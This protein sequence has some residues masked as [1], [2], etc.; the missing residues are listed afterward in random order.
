MERR[1]TSNVSISNDNIKCLIEVSIFAVN[2]TLKLFRATVAN[3]DI[4]GQKSLHIFLKK[5]LYHMVV[6]FEQN[7]TIQTKRNFE[8]LDKKQVFYNHF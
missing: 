5:C 6:K 1:Y 7:R 4:G 2:L 8:L 3:A